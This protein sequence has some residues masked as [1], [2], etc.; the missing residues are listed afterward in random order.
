[1]FAG[2]KNAKCEEMRKCLGV[3]VGFSV[4]EKDKLD[5]EECTTYYSF[6]CDD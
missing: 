1:M 2:R 3:C 5:A 4:D 6:W